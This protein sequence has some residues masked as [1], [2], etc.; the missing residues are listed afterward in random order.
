MSI[1]RSADHW[2][3]YSTAPRRT[4]TSCAT[5]PRLPEGGISNAFPAIANQRYIL[6]IPFIDLAMVMT[7]P[8]ARKPTKKTFYI[9]K[10]ANGNAKADEKPADEKSVAAIPAPDAQPVPTKADKRKRAEPVDAAKVSPVAG[11]KAKRVKKEKVVRDSFT[12]PKYDYE[13][14]AVLKQ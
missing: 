14:I 7:A 2:C 4:L 6:F 11:E 9:P 3:A 13:K 12:L 10:S 8:S 5:C 1:L